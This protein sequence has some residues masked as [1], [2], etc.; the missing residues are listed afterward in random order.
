MI[1]GIGN[2]VCDIRRIA[3]VCARRG[4]D[5]F[6]RK[7]L[8]PS[9]QRVWQH[10]SARLAQRGMAYLA[11]RFSAKESF[12]KAIGLGLHL[13]MRMPD[14]EIL[15]H[16]SGQPYIHLHGELATWFHARGWQAQVTLSDE[17]DYAFTVVVVTGAAAPALPLR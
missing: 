12:S 1:V 2:D 9:E 8:G 16:P 4:D 11:T 17:T 7:V 14:C 13:P 6:A 10:R 3:E 5:R 15:N